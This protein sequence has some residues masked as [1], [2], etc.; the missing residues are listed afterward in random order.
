VRRWRAGPTRGDL[1]RKTLLPVDVALGP[2]SS[3]LDTLGDGFFDELAGLPPGEWQRPVSSAFGLHLVRVKRYQ[4]A[5]PPQVDAVRGAVLEDGRRAQAEAIR[6][7]Q[8]ERMRE[9]Y[10]VVR[11]DRGEATQ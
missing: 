7:A 4:P 8:F 6:G 11:E 3:V 1:G 5:E 9:Q 10:T 2:A